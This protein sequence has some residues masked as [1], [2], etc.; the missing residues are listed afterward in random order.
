M[1]HAPVIV[2]VVSSFGAVCHAASPPPVPQSLLACSELKDLTERAHCYDTQIAAL[3]AAGTS[4]AS[5]AGPLSSTPA[6]AAPAAAAVARAPTSAAA[7]AAPTPAVA[8]SP[9]V[10]APVVT[11]PIAAMAAPAASAA[12][13]PVSAATPAPA[14][15]ASTRQQTAAANFG[16]ELLPYKERPALTEGDRVLLSSI[17]A[18]RQVRPKVFLISLANGQTWLQEGSQITIFFRAGNDARIEKGILGSYRMSTAQTG[19]KN[20]V[21]VTRLQ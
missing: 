11:A 17:T 18:V 1:K 10:A 3:K 15:V 14:A 2:A 8:P 6:P 12:A 4:A 20:W 13:A 21:R 9:A 16:L 7:V 5:P 19:E